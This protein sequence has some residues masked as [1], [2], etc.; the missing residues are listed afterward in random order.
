MPLHCCAGAT[1]RSELQPSETRASEKKYRA[2]PCSPE[3]RNETRHRRCFAAAF[4][5]VPGIILCEVNCGPMFTHVA[6]QIQDSTRKIASFFFCI[7]WLRLVK[8]V[9]NPRRTRGTHRNLCAY[10][11]FAITNCIRS[12]LLCLLQYVCYSMFATVYLPQYVYYSMFTTVCLL[13][14]VYY[15]MFTTYVY[16][17]MFTTV[18]LLQHVY[19]S[20]FT[21]VSL[22]QYVYLLQ[23]AYYGMF[24]VCLLLQQYVSP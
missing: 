10:I 4:C 20:V 16:H 15:S 7:L 18:C 8:V 2:C 9:N 24:T 19:Y 17:S 5:G 13:Q 23:Y 22:L 14:Y 21:T 11:F 6:A 12:W 1:F 3:T